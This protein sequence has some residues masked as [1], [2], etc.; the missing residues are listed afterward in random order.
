MKPKKLIARKEI[1]YFG[2]KL[3]VKSNMKYIAV[4]EY[5]DMYAFTHKPILRNTAITWV[6]NSEKH[7]DTDLEFLGTVKLEKDEDW[8]ETLRK[9]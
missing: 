8:R 9:I 6:E 1:E 2:M 3:L 4:D 7:E 5:G